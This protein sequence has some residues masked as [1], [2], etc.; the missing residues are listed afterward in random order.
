MKPIQ[1]Q[2][3]TL[4][5]L[6]V[7]GYLS[8]GDAL[9]QNAKHNSR[10]KVGTYNDTIL[11]ASSPF[12]D[13]TESAISADEAGIARALQAYDTQANKVESVLPAMKRDE[14]KTLVADIRKAKKQGDYDTIALKSPEAY[15]TLIEALNHTSLKVPIEVSL[16]DYAGFKFQAL[17]HAK[18]GDWK[19]LQKVGD[20]A[21][22]NWAAIKSRVN[23]RSLRDTMNITIRGMNRACTSKNADMALFAAQVDLALVDLLEANFE[24]VVK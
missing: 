21:Q 3:V 9:S 5:V 2:I 23:D 6:F 16:L 4:A 13:L 8:I 15:R 19:A 24:K 11:S 14:L 12:E 7:F 10:T 22:E 18:P 1:K 20:Q 17:L